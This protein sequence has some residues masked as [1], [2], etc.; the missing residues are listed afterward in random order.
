MTKYTPPNPE[1]ASNEGNFPK[2]A[3]A[4][5]PPGTLSV[6]ALAAWGF[7]VWGFFPSIV[8]PPAQRNP[9]FLEV[10]TLLAGIL[11]SQARIMARPGLLVTAAATSLL[12]MVHPL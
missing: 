1:P 4:E 5:A 8:C 7:G 6:G 10:V 9:S 2:G 12:T 11:F 3:G